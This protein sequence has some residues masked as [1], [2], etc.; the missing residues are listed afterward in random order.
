MEHSWLVIHALATPSPDPHIHSCS[1]TI[2]RTAYT[3]TTTPAPHCL[4]SHFINRPQQH[5]WTLTHLLLTFTSTCTLSLRALV[6]HIP[7]CHPNAVYRIVS[8]FSY[9]VHMRV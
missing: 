7:S 3:P 5:G 8:A 6:Y 1:H 9:L 2:T 4:P